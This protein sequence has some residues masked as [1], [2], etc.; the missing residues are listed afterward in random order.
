MKFFITSKL[1]IL[2]QKYISFLVT[3]PPTPLSTK[4]SSPL[5]REGKNYCS[6][7]PVITGGKGWGGVNYL[8][9]KTNK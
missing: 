9:P 8:I 5:R 4:V 7:S 6:L 2:F 3:S 1:Y